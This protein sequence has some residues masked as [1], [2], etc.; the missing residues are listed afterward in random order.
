MYY[1]FAYT[2]DKQPQIRPF[3][4]YD[5]STD[6]NHG[7]WSEYGEWERYDPTAVYWTPVDWSKVE[8]AQ[9]SRDGQIGQ[10]CYNGG[11]S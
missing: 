11:L 3:V 1:V 2:A 5:N 10:L 8:G 9:T 6:W 7:E 4:V